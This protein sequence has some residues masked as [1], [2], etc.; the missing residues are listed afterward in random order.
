MGDGGIADSSVPFFS[1]PFFSFFIPTELLQR[2]VNHGGV[3]DADVG[4]QW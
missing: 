1:F 4:G 2:L 3:L